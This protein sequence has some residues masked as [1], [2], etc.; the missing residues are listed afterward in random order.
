VQVFDLEY[1]LEASEFKGKYLEE[2]EKLLKLLPDFSK[3]LLES[4]KFI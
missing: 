1:N 2:F 4:K 3:A